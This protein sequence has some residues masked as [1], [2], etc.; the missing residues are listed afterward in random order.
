MR[1]NR[2]PT[3]AKPDLA[4][5]IAGELFDDKFNR[6]SHERFVHLQGE[7]HLGAKILDQH[8]GLP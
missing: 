8:A 7:S 3:C 6:I 5:Q 2:R 1:L 4:A